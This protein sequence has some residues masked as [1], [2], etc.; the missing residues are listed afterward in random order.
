MNAKLERTPDAPHKSPVHARMKTVALTCG[1]VLAASNAWAGPPFITDDPEP[2]ETGTFENYLFVEGTRADGEFG[3]P[4][5]GAEINYGPFADTQLT[6]SF[7]LNPNPGPGGYG[8]VWSP[9]GVG[10]KYRFIEED[11]QGWRPQV[12]FFPSVAIPVGSAQRGAPVTWLLPLWAQKSF[13]DV[14]VFGGGGFTV[15]PGEGNRDF[16]NWGLAFLAPV[17]T[18]LQLGA[19]IFG[20]SRAS[21]SDGGSAA[22]GA[23]AIYDFDQTW[24]L[25][26]SVNTGIERERQDALS[27]NVALKWTR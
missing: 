25:V 11:E 5:V 22:V 8:I 23:A 10:V 24:H 9:L 4:A 6:F 15:N 14:T 27:F 3:S 26:G 12:A 2:T 1:L 7:P 16:E 21:I 19:E 17:T 20:V 18:K 13:G